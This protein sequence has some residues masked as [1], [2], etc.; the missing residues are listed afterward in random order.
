M[1]RTGRTGVQGAKFMAIITYSRGWRCSGDCR[2][3]DFGM[4]SYEVRYAAA[5]STR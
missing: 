1:D 3:R 4:L 5:L 2:R